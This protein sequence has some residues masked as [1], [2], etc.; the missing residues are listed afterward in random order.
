[1]SSEKKWKGALWKPFTEHGTNPMID[2][3]CNLYEVGKLVGEPTEEEIS[4][5]IGALRGAL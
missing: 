3:D 4:S 1:M 5:A 2:R